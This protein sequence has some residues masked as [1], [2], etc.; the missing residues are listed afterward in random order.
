MHI[1]SFKT[2]IAIIVVLLMMSPIIIAGGYLGIEE[3]NQNKN[4]VNSQQKYE[5]ELI[6]TQTTNTLDKVTKIANMLA[7][8][9]EVKSMNFDTIDPYV[10]NMV[11]N[12]SILSYTAVMGTDGFQVYNSEGKNK[13]GNRANRDYFKAAMKGQSGFSNVLISD[14]TKKP[15]VVA[16]AP[17]KQNGKIIGVLS[18]NV[19]LD[20][21]S[22]IVVKT[23]NG[24]E[25]QAYIVDRQG[26]VIAHKNKAIVAKLSDFS[27]LKPVKMALE[28]QSGTIEYNDNGN[29]VIATFA[30]VKGINW[31]IVVETNKSVAYKTVN[32]LIVVLIVLAV[33]CL[34]IALIASF[35]MADYITKPL[36]YILKK[37][38]LA[39][40]GDLE[41][42]SLKGTI[43][44]R[45]DEFG[46]IGNGFNN[47]IESISN[48]VKQIKTSNNVIVESSNSLANI[49]SEVANATNEVAKAIEE[50]SK[51][52]EDQANETT[53]GA[54]KINEL[55]EKIDVVSTTTSEMK[56]ISFKA[57]SITMQ[58]LN[59]VKSLME[60]NTE[61]NDA[62]SKVSSSINNLNDSSKKV[63]T[64]IDQ[65]EEIT[66]QTNLLALNAAIEAARAGEA[67]KGFAVVADEVRGLS[68]QS[69]LAAQNISTIIGQ[70]QS[71]TQEA[72]DSMAISEKI[73]IEQNK[74][75]EETRAIFNEISSTIKS[76]IE[77]M[78]DIGNHSSQMMKKKDEI[79]TI[80][81]NIA[82]ASEEF[83]A[84]TE[85]VSASTEE[86]L[87]STE[88][89][90]EHANDLE[91]LAE[92]LKTAVNKFKVK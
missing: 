88:M 73:V 45:E 31:S 46:Q 77:K 39:A 38:K 23:L 7:A 53:E 14:S 71:Q 90:K 29:D 55:S 79:V 48:L 15:I 34:I 32:N 74:S 2:K 11:K 28:K 59:S 25:G 37:T 8:S 68:E 35:L 61:N 16:Y 60:K 62:A 84:S 75:V 66:E 63:S 9:S 52:S 18:I 21:F 26:K 65:I 44:N 42:S 57:D 92:D 43:I 22:D 89:M 27:K 24:L 50:V 54:S 6:S 86:Q 4:F 5:E 13:L 49:T 85:E 30:P 51:G 82:A 80:M 67:G 91:K 12:N 1:K 87:S 70:M 36:K 81:G 40:E 3:L 72:V 83:S 58:G 33:A 76:L 69:S 41:N 20:S 17:I 19:S 64:I 78:N 56:E 10:E 47:M